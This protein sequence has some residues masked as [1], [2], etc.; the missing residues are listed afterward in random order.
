[1]GSGATVV[2]LGLTSYSPY[3]GVS[4]QTAQHLEG[5]ARLGYDVYYVEDHGY[6]PYDPYLQVHTDDC[7]GTVRF[8][9][10]LMVRLGMEDRWAYRDIASDWQV[11]GMSEHRL[12]EL[13]RGADVLLNLTGSTELRDVHRDVP[14]RL[15]LET[16]PV[17][18]QIEIAN[19]DQ[20]TLELMRAHT[21]HASYGEN[22]GAPDCG[23]PTGAF[24]YILTRPPVILDWWTPIEV[25]PDAPYT[26]IANWEQSF[27]DLE[28]GGERYTWSKHVEFLKLVDLPSQSPRPLELALATN[29]EE[30]LSLLHGH[31]WSV[32]DGIGVSSTL[33]RYRD[34]VRR[35]WGEFTVAKD[36]NVRLRSGWFSDRSACYLAA[37]RPVVTQDT[38]FS[39]VLPTGE[40]LFAFRERDEIL[41]AFA[42]IEAEPDRHQRGARR[43]AENWFR[44]EDVLA[45]LMSALATSAVPAGGVR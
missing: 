18:A 3:A 36:Q 39:N 29:N 17:L 31:G 44:A 37:G 33:D 41:A 19:G 28:W 32:L 23:V 14:V 22:F 25:D 40:G 35:S 9:S 24:D 26:T 8:I 7:S 16:D 13:L 5:L 1:M 6:W 10:E 45:A 42:A 20:R 27:K 38:G 2:V 15:Y 30:A 4:W 12:S 11:F 34:Y 21:H 43:V